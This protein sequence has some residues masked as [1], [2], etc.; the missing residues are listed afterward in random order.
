MSFFLAIAIMIWD[1]RGEKIVDVQGILICL[2]TY[3]LK[4]SIFKV[5]V[6]TVVKSHV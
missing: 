1:S 6:Y 2:L 3:H 4:K 5:L